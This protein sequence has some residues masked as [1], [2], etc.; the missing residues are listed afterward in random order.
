MDKADF[1]LS[2]DNKLTS[3]VETLKLKQQKNNIA[4]KLH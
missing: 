3:Y 1:K 4:R 2:N